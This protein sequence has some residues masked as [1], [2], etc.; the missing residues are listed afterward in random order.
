[1]AAEQLFTYRKFEELL[2]C[3]LKDAEYLQ[4]AEATGEQPVTENV[5]RKLI[6][7]TFATT[8]I[9]IVS[10]QSTQEIDQIFFVGPLT[11]KV[12]YYR[13]SFPQ[14]L[15]FSARKNDVVSRLGSPFLLQYQNPLEPKIHKRRQGEKPP[16]QYLNYDLSGFFWGFQ[17]DRRYQDEMFQVDVRQTSEVDLA[18]GYKQ[19]GQVTEAIKLFEQHLTEEPWIAL[20]LAEC[21]EKTGNV[22]QTKAMYEK[23]ILQAKSPSGL[24]LGP[25]R[26]KYSAFLEKIGDLGP[27]LEQLFSCLHDKKRLNSDEQAALESKIRSLANSLGIPM[28]DIEKRLTQHLQHP[29]S[30]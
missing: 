27:A 16:I 25:S 15:N 20:E 9:A 13:G 23:A 18:R 1:M 28:D 30:N 17:F 29:H 2:G 6:Q 24:V 5:T 10:Y 11:N 26:L 22:A 14:S 7:T 12:D 21:Y 8:G 3:T 19:A 4:F